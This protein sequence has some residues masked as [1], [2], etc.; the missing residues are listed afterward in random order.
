MSSQQETLC[1]MALNRATWRMR[2][3]VT[4][5]RIVRLLHTLLLS[6][7]MQ[8]KLTATTKA[9]Q[10]DRFFYALARYVGSDGLDMTASLQAGLLQSD[11][12]LIAQLV[13]HMPA[14]EDGGTQC[15]IAFANDIDMAMFA[16]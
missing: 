10:L 12:A 3:Q 11:D 14:G 16:A 9:A 5:L 1:L 13:G 4:P 6:L 15:C 2:V 8:G 7:E